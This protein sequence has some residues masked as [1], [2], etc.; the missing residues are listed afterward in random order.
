[1][2]RRSE[3]PGPREQRV[4]VRL[5]R[6][7]PQDLA[8]VDLL[9]VVA[10][11]FGVLVLLRETTSVLNLWLLLGVSVFIG[12]VGAYGLGS[13]RKRSTSAQPP[14][15]PSQQRV[16]RAVAAM[17]LGGRAEVVLRPPSST[18]A[19]DQP[20]RERPAEAVKALEDSVAD[21]DSWEAA[22]GGVLL[23]FARGVREPRELKEAIQQAE[24]E[25]AP[26]YL[27]AAVSEPVVKLSSERQYRRP[28]TRDELVKV[29]ERLLNAFDQ[30][31]GDESERAIA[32]V[33]QTMAALDVAADRTKRW[34]D[35]RKAL[36]EAVEREQRSAEPRPGRR[37]PPSGDEQAAG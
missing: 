19:P 32:F 22:L 8:L 36:I 6:K 20:S 7:R 12:L 4:A 21:W 31:T 9:S 11:V 37:Y 24:Q 16:D 14:E 5:Q 1:M 10:L 29:A 3:E 34:V 30:M 35:L 13:A 27:L 17:L 15:R 18:S 28:A 23:K 2:D 26:D 25:G 33:V